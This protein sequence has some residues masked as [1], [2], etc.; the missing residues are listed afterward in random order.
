[1]SIRGLRKNQRFAVSSL[2]VL[3]N[4]RCGIF[5]WSSFQEMLSFWDVAIDFSPEEWECLE[6]AQWDLY[7][8]VMLENFSHLVFLGEHCI[9]RE[10]LSHPYH[11][12]VG[13]KPLCTISHGSIS[14]TSFIPIIWRKI[15]EVAV[16]LRN[17]SLFFLAVFQACLLCSCG[18]VRN[19]PASGVDH[20]C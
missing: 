9:Y 17:M 5:H 4:Y 8:D 7:R 6:P 13:Y 2:V 19:A 16:Q 14:T 11:Q 10:F 18:T 12:H 3:I 15:R 1:M 20:T